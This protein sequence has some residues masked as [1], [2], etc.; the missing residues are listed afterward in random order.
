MDAEALEQRRESI[1]LARVVVVAGDQHALDPLGDELGEEVVDEL[2]GLG[3]RR[4][5]VEDVAGHQD[6]VYFFVLRDR[7]HLVEGLRVLVHALAAAQRLPDVPVGR[8]E[9]PHREGSLALEPARRGPMMF[10]YD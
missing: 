5:R 1:E 8:V 3:R 10:S 4:R 2:L 7:G 9:K 6:G